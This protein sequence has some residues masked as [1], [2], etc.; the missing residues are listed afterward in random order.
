MK[1][2]LHAELKQIN[3]PLGQLVLIGAGA[4]MLLQALHSLGARKILAIEGT[5]S[6]YSVLQRKAKKFKNVETVNK[7]V[8]PVGK[9]CQQ[10]YF[11][12]NPRFNS[13][14]P[15]N[16]LESHHQNVKLQKCT[17]IDGLAIDELL[18]S[19]KLKSEVM[20]L[21][22]MTC[23]RAEKQI[24]DGIS[25]HLLQ[26]FGLI[27][28]GN[29]KPNPEQETGAAKLDDYAFEKL[30]FWSS[31]KDTF[32]YYR[33]SERQIHAQ[34]LLEQSKRKEVSIKKSY[35]EL[36]LQVAKL[37]ELNEVLEAS[38]TTQT[39]RYNEEVIGLKYELTRLREVNSDLEHHKSLMASR[40]ELIEFENDRLS[41]DN[42]KLEEEVGNLRV[43]VKSK[44]EQAEKR[45]KEMSNKDLE[46]SE[47][48]GQIESLEKR[49]SE[50]ESTNQSIDGYRLILEDKNSQLTEQIKQTNSQR[51]RVE[52]LADTNAKLLIKMQDDTA[53]LR[54]LVTS[55]NEQLKDLALLIEQLHSKLL[56]A[57]NVYEQLKVKHPELDW[58]RF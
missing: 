35:D 54:Q 53:G 11:Y 3:K 22:V 56:Q 46:L 13:L 41:N 57:S 50:L 14:I 23:Q 25:P 49:M 58:E 43:E 18:E 33:L 20:N 28:L 34:K 2:Y 8:M 6:L 10:V 31:P 52:R 51:A 5:D 39:K 15:A 9:S 45:Q 7:W 40:L 1:E 26:Q 36:T 24:L 17:E 48:A 12:N 32:E 30:P 29:G 38:E 4:G 21:L 42:S 19:L 47:K 44:A 37:T 16:N 27:V 55:K